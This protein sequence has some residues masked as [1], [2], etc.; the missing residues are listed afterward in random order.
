MKNNVILAGRVTEFSFSH[1]VKECKMYKGIISIERHSGII[2]NIPFM[3]WCDNIWLGEF[4]QIDGEINTFNKV[5]TNGV[6]HKETFVKVH[7]IACCEEKYENYV[8]LT[9]YVVKRDSVRVTPFGK[10]IADFVIAWNNRYKKSHYPSMI[11]WGSSAY[12]I[13][14][15]SIGD[16]LHIV[17]RF[18]SREYTKNDKTLTAYEISCKSIDKDFEEEDNDTCS[19]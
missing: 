13:K 3:T 15:C 4:Y 12:L 11:S 10:I 6:S 9:G 16:K 18:Q 8:E 17:G 7:S 19:D 1:K 2:D 5:D 14:N